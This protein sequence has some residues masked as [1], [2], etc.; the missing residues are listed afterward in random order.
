MTLTA[1]IQHAAADGVQLSL[2]PAGSIKVSGDQAAVTRWLPTIRAHK[3]DIIAEMRARPATVPTSWG[4]RLT[5]PS[6]DVVEV[7]AVPEMTQA[8]ALAFDGQATD[9]QPIAGA[10]CQPTTNRMTADE[11]H[12]IRAWLTDIG[13]NDPT[14]IADVIADCQI[15]IES[16]SYFL[17]RA[18]RHDGQDRAHR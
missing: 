8:E 9:A 14:T 17:G 18:E 11:E 13:E 3:P 5:L 16:R 2:T 6:G 7:F 15:N 12:A 10:S 1:I 4:W